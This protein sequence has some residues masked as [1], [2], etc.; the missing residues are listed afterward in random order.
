M[1]KDLSTISQTYFDEMYSSNPDPW[2]FEKS[3]YEKLKYAK[4]LES[5]PNHQYRNALEVGCSIGILTQLLAKRCDQLMAIDISEVALSH[6]RKRLQDVTNVT[7]QKA[8]IPNDYPS[9]EYD[10]V[11]LSEVGYYLSM[12]DLH[13]A[14]ENIKKDLT[15]QGDLVL[16]HWT[17][18]VD[19]YPLTGDQVHE[20]F[21]DDQDL[22]KL[23]G[24][25][26]ADYRLDV[27][28]KK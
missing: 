22:I 7:I 21:I 8:S 12:E 20:V 6:A 27:F 28:R 16:I 24:F 23:N 17:H 11:L 25:K 9:S 3:E 14:K 5:L 2:D 15:A 26:T 13:T 1:K 10:L 4:T 19:D 18:Y